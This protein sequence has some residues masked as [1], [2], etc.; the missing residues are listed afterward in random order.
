MSR[1]T[2][3]FVACSPHPR[4]GVSTTARLLTDFYLSR[5]TEVEGFDTDPHAPRYHEWFP[6]RTRVID[7]ADIRG[8]ISLFDRL[9][10]DDGVPKIVDVWQRAYD[11]FFKTVKEIGFVEEA[12][13]RGV[14]P[15][16]LFHVD[17]TNSALASAKSL[18]AAWR[19]VPMV[20][21]QNEGAA[22]LG[23][24]AHET[25]GHYPSTR[26]FLIGA[27]DGAVA[28]TLDEPDLSLSRLLVSPPPE[29][30][31]VIRAALK[32]WIA[33]IFTQFRSFELRHELDGA[34]FL[35]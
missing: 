2:L 12:R 16:V 27:L 4:S 17:Q 18:S 29:M 26:R 11:R 33:P 25:L 28:K 14:E 15:I 32:A 35:K 10:V 23:A 8:Q 1:R 20:I 19:D 31:I 9:L 30:S 7:T 6:D 21:V 3:V 34:Q 5:L 24:Y 13:A 22:P